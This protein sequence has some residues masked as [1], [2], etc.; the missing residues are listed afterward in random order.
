LISPEKRTSP[1]TSGSFSTQ[2]HL[3]VTSDKHLLN[4]DEDALLLAFN[5]SD[6]APVHPVQSETSVADFTLSLAGRRCPEHTS[7][8]LPKRKMA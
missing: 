6:L 5:E 7:E 1:T 4:I 3:L 8:I 2:I